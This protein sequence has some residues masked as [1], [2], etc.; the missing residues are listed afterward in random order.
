MAREPAAGRTPAR[1]GYFG[2]IPTH[3]DFVARNLPRPVA[4][5]LDLWTR[6]SVRESQRALGRDWLDAFLVAPVW[7]GAAAAGVLGPEPAALV[8]MPSVDRVGRYFPLVL[9]TA[10]PGHRGSLA[11]L[12]RRVLPWFERAERLALST[13]EPDFQREAL[14]RGADALDPLYWFQPSL[15]ATPHDRA[16]SL[17]WT[18]DGADGI[19]GCEAM[20]PPER[21][22]ALFLAG[23]PRAAPGGAPAAA[24]SAAARPEPVADA[25]GFAESPSRA[26]TR[27][28][29]AVDCA[30]A[31]L[32]GTRSPVLTDAVAIGEDDQAMSVVSGIG[33][34]PG[35]RGAVETVRDA[36][37]SIAE[38]FSMNDLVAE[39]KGKL[40]RANAML[41]ARAMPGGMPFAASAAT[42][43]VQGGRH[44]VLWAGN[45]RAYLLRDGT[46]TALTRD[47]V[48][49]VIAGAVT[50]AVGAARQLSLESAIGEAR[51]GDRFLLCS[52]GLV[53]ALSEG[54]IAETLASA[55]SARQAA[56]HLVQDALI[57]GAALDV[58]ALAAILR[59]KDG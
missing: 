35:L 41:Q 31:A 38:P 8:M 4:D 57:A 25:E 3:G 50:R 44:A 7:R 52:A 49:P 39:A 46:M 48:D 21:F 23:T 53:G 33:A 1:T 16:R 42:L 47:H 11:T 30:G 14:D 2:K 36:L 59:L 18:G 5:A 24:A 29:L 37:A 26:P 40:G 54:E 32:K 45:V 12:P 9:A 17:W 20:P 56:D 28:L 19:V 51:P 13:L 43:L 22:H 27:T 34:H 58:A 15:R 10:L 6:E 55:A